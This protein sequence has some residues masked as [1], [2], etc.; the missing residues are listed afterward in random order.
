MPWSNEKRILGGDLV[1]VASNLFVF[2]MMATTFGTTDAWWHA[3]VGAVVVGVLHAAAD[4]S[5]LGFWA[6]VVVAV[7]AGAV[8]VWAALN[9]IVWETVSGDRFMQ[10]LPWFFLALAVGIGLN[11]LVFSIL[12]PIPEAGLLRERSD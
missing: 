12:R 2:V 7:L 1:I 9:A 10:S 11:R 8:I 3:A 6:V 4:R 5:R